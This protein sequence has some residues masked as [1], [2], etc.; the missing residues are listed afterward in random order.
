MEAAR[1]RLWAL[2]H[3]RTQRLASKKRTDIAVERGQQLAHEG[4]VPQA[5]YA[6]DTGLL[7]VERA[8]CIAGVGK[9]G[10]SEVA[11][12]RHIQWQGHWR[13]VDAVAAGLRR[14]PPASLRAGRIRGRTGETKQVWA[15]TKMD[16]ACRRHGVM[17]V[18]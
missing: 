10:V 9:Q 2:L 5:N 14:A 16:D 4:H 18:V 12:S 17:S 7:T 13:R 1:T 6:F 8:R 3:H 11:C 15:F